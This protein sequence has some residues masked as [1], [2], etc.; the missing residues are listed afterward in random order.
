MGGWTE[1]SGRLGRGEVLSW[2]L[3]G[4]LLEMMEKFRKDEDLRCGKR[5]GKDASCMT[6]RH[7]LFF[8]LITY[9][10]YQ[11]SKINLTLVRI[12]GSKTFTTNYLTS[13]YLGR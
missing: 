1:S 4:V 12:S 7:G 11:I 6:D 3:A 10:Y 5:C 8:C 13:R 9:Y 2:L